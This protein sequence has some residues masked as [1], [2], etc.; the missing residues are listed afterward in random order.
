MP[1]DKKIRSSIDYY[2]IAARQFKQQ[3]LPGEFP[4]TTVWGYGSADDL[5]TFNYPA[6]TIE[7]QTNHPVKIKWINDLLDADGNYLKHLLPIDQTLHWANPPMD[8]IDSPMLSLTK[9]GTDCRGKNQS[10][11]EGPVPIVT[12]LHGAH[13]KP[14]SD[15]YPE[16]WF[17]PN[18]GREIYNRGRCLSVPE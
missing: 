13:V 12:H 2:E 6:R 3:L 9:M 15:G 4:K 1:K 7:A 5:S 11:Y 17:L 10:P 8:C 16:A 18:R 14:N